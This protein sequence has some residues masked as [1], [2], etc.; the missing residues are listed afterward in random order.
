LTTTPSR[1]E[2]R[3][4]AGDVGGGH[5]TVVEALVVEALMD[6]AEAAADLGEFLKGVQT[7]RGVEGGDD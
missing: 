4:R 3:H 1:R 6:I 7:N 5:V 2:C